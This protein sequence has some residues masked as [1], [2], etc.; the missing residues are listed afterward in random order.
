[1]RDGYSTLLPAVKRARVMAGVWLLVLAGGVFGVGAQAAPSITS[2]SPESGTNYHRVTITG[3]GLGSSQGTSTV[4]F[5]GTEAS[6]VYEWSDTE[7]EARPPTSLTVGAHA[8]VVTVGGVGSNGVDYTRLPQL[9]AYCLSPSQTIAEPSGTFQMGVYRIGPT[10]DAVTVTLTYSGTATHGADY[11]APATL[12]IAAGDR[13]EEATLEVVDDSLAE[14]DE[15]INYVVSAEGYIGNNCGITLEDDNDTGSATSPTI[16]GL[17]P[18]TG[19]V[20]TSVEITGLNFGAIRGTSTVSFNQTAVAAYTSW[21]AS[22]IVVEVPTGAT[23]GNVVVTVGGVASNGVLFTGTGTAPTPGVTVRPTALTIAEG[24]T[25]TYTVVLD[26][27]PA[28]AVTVTVFAGSGLSVDRFPVFGVTDWATPQ[29]VTVTADQDGDDQ[30]ETHR[31]SHQTSSADGD[32]H[33]LTV[34]EVEVTVT[35]DEGTGNP[36]GTLAL[37]VS[38]TELRITEGNSGSY[39]V[40]LNAE[41]PEAV[42]VAVRAPVGG[43]LTVMPSLLQFT[44]SNWDEPQEVTVTAGEDADL[45]DEVESITHTVSLASEAAMRGIVG[46]R[47]TFAFSAVPVLAREY[48]Y[49]GGRLVGIDPG[50]SVSS[51]ASVVVTIEDND[52]AGEVG[53][54]TSTPRLVLT[55]GNSGSYTLELGSEPTAEVTV[56]LTVALNAD[57]TV[58]PAML[59]FKPGDP[60]NPGDP[61]R[62]NRSRRVTVTVSQDDDADDETEVIRHGVTSADSDYAGI[63]DFTVTVSIRDDDDEDE[64]VTPGPTGVLMADPNPCFIPMGQTQCTFTLSWTLTNTDTIQVQRRVPGGMNEVILQSGGAGETAT[65]SLGETPGVTY[66]LYDFTNNILG[67]DPLYSVEV[68]VLPEPTGPKI[69]SLSP[70]SGIVSRWVTITGMR[71]GMSQGASTVTFNGTPVSSGGIISWSDTSLD[72]G[73]PAGASSGPVVVAVGEHMSN[74]AHF[75]VR[76]TLTCQAWPYDIKVG[77]SST[78][79]WTTVGASSLTIDDGDAQTAPITVASTDIAAGSRMVTPPATTDYSVKAT[80][81]DGQ[82]AYCTGRVTLWEAPVIEVFRA[83]PEDINEGEVTRLSWGTTHTT[84][85]EIDQGIGYVSVVDGGYVDVAPARTTTYTLTATNRAWEGSD[86]VTAEVEVMVTPNPGGPTITCSPA[87][88][89]LFRGNSETLEWTT[90]GATNLTIDDGD[91]NTIFTAGATEVAR[92]MHSV[93]PDKPTTYRLTATDSNNRSSTCPSTLTPWDAP[94]ISLT[95][96][97]SV[98]ARGESS[99]L[100]WHVA[101][102]TEVTFGYGYRDPR[103]GEIRYVEPRAPRYVFLNGTRVVTPGETSGYT[104][105]ATN[106]KYDIL[107]AVESHVEVTVTSGPPPITCSISPTDIK[108]VQPGASATLK[109]ETTGN[110]SS[111]SISPDPGGGTPGTSGTRVVTPPGTTT[112]RFT[113]TDQGGRS[114]KCAA[115]VT[116]WEQP[117][118]SSFKANPDSI[119]SGEETTLDWSTRHA[120]DVS[121]RPDPGGGAPGASGSRDVSPSADTTYTLTA[122]NPAWKETAATS[123]TARVTVGGAP[124]LPVIDSFTATPGRI[125]PNGSSTLRWS[126]TGATSVSISPTVG[127]VAVDGNT[128]VSPTRTTEYELTATNA[129]GSVMATAKVIVRPRIDSFTATPSTIAPGGSSTL[130]WSTTGAKNVSIDQGIG[131]VAVDGSRVVTPSSTTTYTLRASNNDGDS[132]TASVTVTVTEDPEP[133]CDSFTA[134]PA[135]IC[136]GGSS[137][138]RWSTTDADSVSIDQGIGSVAVDGS[139]SVSPTTTTYTLTATNTVGSDSCTATVTVVDPPA[140]TISASRTTINEGQPFTLSWSSSN[141]DSASI[142]QGINSVTPNVSGSRSLRPSAGTHT[143]TITATK[144]PCLNATASVTVTVRRKPTGDIEANPNPCKIA[145]GSNTCT[146]T[147]S[148]STQGTNKTLVEVDHLRRA[149]ATGGASGN[150]NATWIQEAPANS[151]TF[152]LYDYM[153]SVKGTLIKSVPVTGIRPPPPVIDSFTANPS[154][155]TRGQTSTLRWTTT[156]ARDVILEGR[157]YPANGNQPVAPWDTGGHNYTVTAR[158]ADGQVS[159]S[160]TVTVSLPPPPVIHSLSPRQGVPD[161]P[162]TIYGRNFGAHQSQGSV[163]FGGIS[164]D[165]NSWSSS[166][167]SVQVPVQL[168]WGPVSVSLTTNG[169]TSNSLT[170]TVT[171][172]S[173]REECEE[174]EED[175]PEEDEEDCDEDEED[176]PDQGD[177]D[178]DDNSGSSP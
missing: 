140:A 148:W 53:I 88:S 48:V 57:V 175:C 92:G 84:S 141:A 12:T 34:D 112:Y 87:S 25:G 158:N 19:A 35:D 14:G 128:S 113:A 43:D 166:S 42:T 71:F 89:D 82:V 83:D 124:G 49:L 163:S 165:I 99:T 80:G 96:T 97:P 50:A 5:G 173:P 100:E 119:D 60:G 132:D 136:S 10:T 152:K 81:P 153:D 109:W 65:Q 151:Y 94:I 15:R 117:V 169:L 155:I 40:V 106:P 177:G 93:I 178:G 143:Y 116:V 54:P 167:V 20:G 174:N 79:S 63:A 122:S 146:T 8:V 86:G 1:M 157:T 22:S 110:I 135:N 115:G 56:A 51:V 11:T 31:I 137:T 125:A 121:I 39:T 108:L 171:G 101:N 78:L 28:A 30:D 138:L 160:V 6:R 45:L 70:D 147:I 162:V 149:F 69:T 29:T 32:Y 72:V 67:Q 24:D 131:S 46:G 105:E 62:W 91:G 90:T 126:T 144:A 133:R 58:S 102:A 41:P 55:E 74:G 139:R 176:C 85:V 44:V 4:T 142:N 17:N 150:Q 159:A 107:N 77:A 161:S 120:T 7:I 38:T 156:N 68:S 36:G 3:T 114:Y 66:D 26:T 111:V 168:N 23:T 47:S 129:V 33:G 27:Q 145:I 98:I 76:P 154:S 95:A 16:S 52:D 64:L 104:L 21:S 164:A 172:D 123:A 134:S 13:R 9:T 118:V 37:T 61:E 73:V 127:S 103:T 170:F 59:T 2:I 18:A 75:T 130:R